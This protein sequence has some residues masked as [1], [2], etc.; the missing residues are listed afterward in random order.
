MQQEI[1]EFARLSGDDHWIHV[2]VTRAARELPGG[3]TIVHGLYLVS[4]VPRLQRQLFRIKCRGAGLNYGYDKVRFTAPVTVGSRIRLT[5]TVS[6]ATLR[7]NGT[8]LALSSTIEVQGMSKP[9]LVADAL[10]LIE[11]LPEAAPRLT[12]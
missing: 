10:L 4:L 11:D 2:D 6:S 3:K 9:A 8:L 7:G 1:D 5:Q 12:A